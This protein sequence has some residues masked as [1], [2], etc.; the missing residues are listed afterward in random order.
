M[1]SSTIQGT[2]EV[3]ILQLVWGGGGRNEIEER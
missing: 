1:F 3:I 2:R